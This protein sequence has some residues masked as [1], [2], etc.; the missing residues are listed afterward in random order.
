MYEG[1]A[2]VA[3]GI[4]A[5]RA[6]DAMNTIV[7]QHLYAQMLYN[8]MGQKNF[9]QALGQMGP[10]GVAG[11]LASAERS[12]GAQYRKAEAQPLYLTGPNATESGRVVRANTEGYRKSTN[13]LQARNAAYSDAATQQAITNLLA[14][15]RLGLISELSRNTASTINAELQQAATSTDQ[16][17]R[18]FAQGERLGSG[19]ME[20]YGSAATGGAMGGARG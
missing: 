9:K 8:Q 4:A 20:M 12:Y 17:S 15:A 3:E 16:K 2:L 5:K 13:T 6:G 18:N 1:P 19:G 11:N 7:A 14:R 10:G